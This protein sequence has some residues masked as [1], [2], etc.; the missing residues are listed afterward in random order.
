MCEGELDALTIQQHAGDII[1]PVATG[2]TSGSRSDKWIARLTACS[3]VL[4]A[5]D[6]DKAGDEAA[7]WWIKTLPNARRWRPFW[8]DANAM[9]VSGADI[10]VWVG[11]GLP[12]SR[13]DP[14]PPGP[15]K[16]RPEC[17]EKLEVELPLEAKLAMLKS[18][19]T[20]ESPVEDSPSSPA[21]FVRQSVEDFLGYLERE[22]LRVAGPYEWRPDPLNPERLHPFVRV[23]EK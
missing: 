17:N 5:F 11:V 21:T 16:V 9:A 12:E 3:T 1:T 13:F 4:V 6:A 7:K 2:S 18:Q 10:R 20:G 22:G 23:I 15:M 8:K 14:T 19:F